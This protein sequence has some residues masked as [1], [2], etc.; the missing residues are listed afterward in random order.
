MSVTFTIYS[1]FEA[2]ELSEKIRRL[3][4]LYPEFENEFWF[5]DKAFRVDMEELEPHYM[6]DDIGFEPISYLS[7]GWNRSR[8]GKYIH[9]VPAAIIAFC[10]RLNV[11]I[12]Y[13]DC[14][15]EVFFGGEK[16][17]QGTHSSL[18]LFSEHFIKS[19]PECLKRF[20][21]KG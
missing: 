7:Y 20:H 10:G 9:I 3:V 8:D 2:D 4:Q 15:G 6:K 17:P 12:E 18:E 14:G 21:A 1:L 16:F 19:L 11:F 5:D 13:V